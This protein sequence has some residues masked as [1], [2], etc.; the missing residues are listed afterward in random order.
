M[1]LEKRGGGGDSTG[2]A[3]IEA[4][5][6]SDTGWRLQ[7]SFEIRREAMSDYAM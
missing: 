7:R 5:C 1:K 3:I 2:L 6:T 4:I